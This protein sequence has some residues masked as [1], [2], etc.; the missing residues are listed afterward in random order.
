MPYLLAMAILVFIVSDQIGYKLKQTALSLN[1]IEPHESTI[2]SHENNGTKHSDP[3]NQKRMAIYHYNEGNKSLQLNN[4]EEAIKNYKMALMHN[5]AFEES[6][7]NLSTA[8]LNNKEFKASL[9]TLK[10]LQKINPNNPFLH[11]NLACYYSII[12]NNNLGLASL[13]QAI[14][15]G[16]KN[17]KNLKKD[18]D[19]KN[20]RLDPKFK[21]IEK[22]IPSKN[23]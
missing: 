5:K 19:L 23:H 12:G 9:E 16:F 1:H 14:K 11:Y 3:E 4:L 8:Y 22:L 13:K 6:Y 15:N 7:I 20:L 10:D 2:H 21:N 17:Y 18:P